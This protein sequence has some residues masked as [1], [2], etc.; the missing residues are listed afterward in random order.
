MQIAQVVH[1]VVAVLFVALIIAHI[2]IGTVGMEGALL[3]VEATEA[4][5][6]QSCTSVEGSDA[7]GR[8]VRSCA[9]PARAGGSIEDPPPPE[10]PIRGLPTPLPHGR[11]RFSCRHMGRWLL[12]TGP[13]LVAVSCTPS[14]PLKFAWFAQP[15]LIEVGSMATVAAGLGAAIASGRRVAVQAAAASRFGRRLRW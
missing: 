6:W 1:S 12:A 3:E 4:Q 10:F 7:L 15:I 13:F 14:R 2:Y 8:W 11:P 5:R 9:F